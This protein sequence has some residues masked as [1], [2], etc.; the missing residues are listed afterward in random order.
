[1]PAIAGMSAQ[2]EAGRMSTCVAVACV[3]GRKTK[4][5]TNAQ[6][7]QKFRNAR[8]DWTGRVDEEMLDVTYGFGTRIGSGETH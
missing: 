6:S 2:Q 5:Q 1:M 4:A 7:R 8:M 3:Q